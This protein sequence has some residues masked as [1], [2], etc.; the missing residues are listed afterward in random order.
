VIVA[1]MEFCNNWWLSRAAARAIR[2]VVHPEQY[3]SE[4]RARLEPE[5]RFIVRLSESEVVCERPDGRVERVT[6][7]DL[8]KVEVV[9]TSEGPMVPDV[10]WVLHG[11]TEGC[12][13]PQGATG[14]EELL[15]RLQALPGFDNGAVIEAML[16][17]EDRRFL[18]WQKAA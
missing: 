11:T 9:T 6:W 17:I 13:V 8:Q 4:R 5:S 1:L 15:H 7:S 2:R 3:A 16:C 10:F 18:C 12:A 14:D